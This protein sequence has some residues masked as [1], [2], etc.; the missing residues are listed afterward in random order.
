MPLLNNTKGAYS[1]GYSETYMQGEVVRMLGEYE[2]TSSDGQL[3]IMTPKIYR[4]VHV[5]EIGRISDIIVYFSDR[6]IFNIECKLFDAN[7]VLKQAKD[8]LLWADYSYACF[9]GNIYLPNY[10]RKQMIEHGIGLLYYIPESGLIEGIMAEYNLKKN[11]D[12]LIRRNLLSTLRRMDATNAQI[13]FD[14]KS[15]TL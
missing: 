2:F 8:H 4:E 3:E 15:D 9:P 11:K 12:T 5:P 7:E 10:R 14:F 1:L 6:K 13:K